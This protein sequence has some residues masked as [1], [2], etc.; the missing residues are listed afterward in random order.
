MTSLGMQLLKEELADLAALI[1]TALISVIYL[2][3]YSAISLAA[4]VKAGAATAL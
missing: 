4:D 1:L 2:A 3:I